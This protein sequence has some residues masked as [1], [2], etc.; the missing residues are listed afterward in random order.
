MRKWI[1]HVKYK[2]YVFSIVATRRS[3]KS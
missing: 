2:A 3:K 1:L